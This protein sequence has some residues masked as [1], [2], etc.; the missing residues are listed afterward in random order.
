M[1]IV[2]LTYKQIILSCSCSSPNVVFNRG[3]LH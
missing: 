1:N 3:L 2:S